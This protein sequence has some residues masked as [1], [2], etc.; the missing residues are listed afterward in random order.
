[1]RSKKLLRWSGEEGP[2]DSA[3]DKERSRADSEE[4]RVVVRVE[5]VVP[6]GLE[7]DVSSGREPAEEKSWEPAPEE[8]RRIR[9]R[10][11]IRAQERKVRV[12]S[13]VEI[14]VREPAEEGAVREAPPVPKK[15]EITSAAVEGL[16]TLASELE[17][18]SSDEALAERLLQEAADLLGSFLRR[19]A[20]GVLPDP[21]TLVPLAEQLVR[22]SHGG[23]FLLRGMIRRKSG[24]GS[25]ECLAVHM[26]DV[27]VL[28]I[29]I[30]MEL[31]YNQDAL[32]SLAWS[33][34]LH[35]IGWIKLPLD[36]FQKKGPSVEEM[37]LI[38]RHPLLGYEFVSGWEEQLP[39]LAKVILQEHEREDGS[40][41]PHSLKGSD[42][43]EFAKVVGISDT[44]EVLIHVK[45]IHPYKALQ[46][47]LAMRDRDF[48]A[49]LVKMLLQVLSVF[50]LESLVRLNTGEVARVVDVSKAHPTRP[51][52]E[53]LLD[54][55]GEKVRERRKVNLAE[56][57]II[58]I[59]DPAFSGS[60]I[61]V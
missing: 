5:I 31:S 60:G 49:K 61:E 48:P 45:D 41:Y 54:S 17:Q 19:A 30:G 43:H 34:L 23:N 15:E 27:A 22:A 46:Q 1:M 18:G 24:D 51:T 50:P 40:G 56:E 16:S 38:R 21:D 2:E 11:L 9:A 53:V 47:V 10:D 37:E 42:I 6:S 55:Q 29:P 7:L 26:V 44:Y 57:P 3:P 12:S 8:R 52:V 32:L 58:Y 20:D 33:A 35:D 36:L 59:A 14:D 4:K 13:A 28:A 39:W 25:I